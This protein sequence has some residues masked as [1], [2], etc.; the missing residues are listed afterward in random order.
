MGPFGFTQNNSECGRRIHLLFL[1]RFSLDFVSESTW[2]REELWWERGLFQLGGSSISVRQLGT[3]VAVSVFGLL[4]SLPFGFSVDGVIFAGRLIVFGLIVLIG[5]FGLVLRRVK[6]VPLELQLFFWVTKL[7]SGTKAKLPVV[8][9]PAEP[10]A[11]VETH[12]ILVDDFKDPTPF[13]FAGTAKV[14]ATK[15]VQLVIGGE[16]RD[17]ASLTPENGSYRLIYRPQ[18]K[19]LGVQ[20]GMVKLQGSDVP[21]S[22]FKI[23]VSAKGV[24][25]LESKE[26]SR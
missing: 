23:V 20:D 21:F 8:V 14:E 11:A 4:A 25:L 3:L 18:P 22:S 2:W 1:Q 13:S 26:H 10:K 9:A 24:N 17:E 15:T 7:R 6:A 12:Q 5:Y 16:V 19:D